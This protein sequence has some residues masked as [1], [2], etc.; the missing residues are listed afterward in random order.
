MKSN[1][2]CDEGCQYFEL[3]FTYWSLTFINFIWVFADALPSPSTITT[4]PILPGNFNTPT[5]SL[6]PSTISSDQVP[7]L[8]ASHSISQVSS[9][10]PNLPSLP[11]PSNQIHVDILLDKIKKLTEKVKQSE[12]EKIQQRVKFLEEL[13]KSE[14]EKKK[15][16]EQCAVRDAKHIEEKNNLKGLLY[17]EKKKV[18]KLLKNTLPTQTQRRKIVEEVLEPFFSKSQIDCFLKGDW[19]RVKKWTQRDIELAISIRTL[20]SKTYKLLRKKKIVPL[21]GLSTLR[22]YF[23]EFQIREG[24]KI[25]ACTIFHY[26]LIFRTSLFNTYLFMIKVFCI[27][28]IF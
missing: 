19:K 12:D 1:F 20:S 13:D 28:H 10:H 24:I 3:K 2:E 5:A 27:T 23:Q 8:P 7:P 21:P 22:R 11:I 26:Q 14:T 17:L 15:L 25:P 4:V 9:S 18:K 6:P 16:Q